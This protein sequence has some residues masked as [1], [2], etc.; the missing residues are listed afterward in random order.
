[1]PWTV[2]AHRLVFTPRRK[3]HK[4][5]Q[6]LPVQVAGPTDAAPTRLRIRSIESRLR[7]LFAFLHQPGQSLPFLQRLLQLRVR[8]REKL[9]V[10]GCVAKQSRIDRTPCPVRPSQGLV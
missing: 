10:I 1:M 6:R 7:Q 8:L 5:G 2:A 9:Y 4:Y 3:I